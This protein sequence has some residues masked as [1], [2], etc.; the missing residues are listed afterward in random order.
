MDVPKCSVYE[1]VWVLYAK[2]YEDHDILID[3]SSKY[4]VTLFFRF[5]IELLAENCPF[6]AWIGYIMVGTI[7]CM[8]SWYPLQLIAS[9]VQLLSYSTPLQYSLPFHSRSVLSS[10]LACTHLLQDLML[11]PM[12]NKCNNTW[13]IKR[14]KLCMT[15][16]YNP[17]VLTENVVVL[18]IFV[19]FFTEYI[20][21]TPL[22]SCGS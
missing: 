14:F 2:R 13:I 18:S 20:K 21:N 17:W 6:L 5:K 22:V 3:L 9:N 1:P 11:Y 19:L 4:S 15:Q 12:C 7:P 10:P 16:G 8:V